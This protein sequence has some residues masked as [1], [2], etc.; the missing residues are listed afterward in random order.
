M[1]VKSKIKKYY[2]FGCT[3]WSYILLNVSIDILDVKERD[4]EKY[5]LPIWHNINYLQL[6]LIELN[7]SKW[8]IT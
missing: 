7:V 8:A 1:F 3:Y 6:I 4:F 5:D 2:I